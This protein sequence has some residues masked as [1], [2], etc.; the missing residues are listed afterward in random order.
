MLK[1]HIIDFTKHCI[2]QCDHNLGDFTRAQETTKAMPETGD[3]VKFYNHGSIHC[4]M[5]KGSELE[6]INLQP[7]LTW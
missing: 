5:V 4:D 3:I 1:R 2:N 7:E 6:C